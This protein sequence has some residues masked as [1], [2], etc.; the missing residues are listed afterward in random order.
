MISFIISLVIGGIIGAI[1][2]AIM[3]RQV[4]GGIIGNVVVGFVGAWL[5]ELV[6]GEWGWAIQDFYVFPSIIGAI[7]VVWLFGLIASRN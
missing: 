4:P 7:V 2:E 5:G 3:N 6:L 1:G